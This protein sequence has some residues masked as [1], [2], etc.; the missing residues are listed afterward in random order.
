MGFKLF[1]FVAFILFLDHFKVFVHSLMVKAGARGAEGKPAKRT[2]CFR[3][4]GLRS[5]WRS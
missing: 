1:V 4:S 5:L 2:F 3:F